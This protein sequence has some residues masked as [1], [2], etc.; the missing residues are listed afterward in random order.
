MCHVPFKF[1]MLSIYGP[2][3][4]Y[5]LVT[6]WDRLSHTLGTRAKKIIKIEN[7][8]K[9]TEFYFYFCFLLSLAL[10]PRVIIALKALCN[11]IKQPDTLSSYKRSIG[12]WIG[13]KCD[14]RVC[15]VLPRVVFSSGWK[16]LHREYR[17]GQTCIL[18]KFV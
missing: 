1:H 17:N 12:I 14:C 8:K 18:H 15:L 13:K 3:T 11:Y 4:C 6:T 10:V 2:A 9:K 16:C 5:N 7:Y